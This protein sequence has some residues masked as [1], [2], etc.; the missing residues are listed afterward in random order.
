MDNIILLLKNY[1]TRRL[2]PH[3]NATQ[4]GKAQS[5]FRIPAPQPEH[6]RSM[7]KIPYLVAHQI[8]IAP[9]YKMPQHHDNPEKHTQ[10]NKNPYQL[11]EGD[12]QHTPGVFHV[13]PGCFGD[14]PGSQ[15]KEQR[16]QDIGEESPKEDGKEAQHNKKRGKLHKPDRHLRQDLVQASPG[17]GGDQPGQADK[18]SPKGQ[19]NKQ[20]KGMHGILRVCFSL[21]YGYRLLCS[22]EDDILHVPVIAVGRRAPQCP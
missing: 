16:Q 13:P 3:N 1:K 10:N 21:L 19:E 8:N 11:Q 20:Q 5:V 9:G 22:V 15:D 2:P 12:E 14:D 7:K 18:N 4:G 6:S 17:Y